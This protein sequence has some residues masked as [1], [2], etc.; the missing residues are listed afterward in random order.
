[1]KALYKQPGKNP[2]IIEIEN[3]LKPLQEAVGGYIE[4]VTFGKYIVVCDEEGRLKD[5]PENCVIEGV[6]FVGD[7]LVLCSEA[8]EFT[9]I[10]DDIAE[11]LIRKLSK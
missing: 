11:E 7:I 3:E 6:H 8:S 4:T 9:D 5:K 1:M 10:K 2:E